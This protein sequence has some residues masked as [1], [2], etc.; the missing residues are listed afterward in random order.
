[1][2][3]AY[4]V[5]GRVRICGCGRRAIARG[6]GDRMLVCPACYDAIRFTVS[7]PAAGSWECQC[8]P[9][10]AVRIAASLEAI[11]AAIT[12]GTVATGLPAG[13]VHPPARSPQ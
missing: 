3:S 12:I 6:S 8:D 7:V 1:M 9:S 13:A 2:T 5:P 11:A 10:A 4:A